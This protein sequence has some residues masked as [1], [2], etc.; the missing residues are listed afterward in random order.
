MTEVGSVKFR[1]ESDGQELAPFAGFEALN[2]A[3]D[4]LRRLGLLGLD[5]NGIGFGNVSLREGSTNFFYIT[6][7]G[8]GGLV[9]LGLTNYARVTAWD[10]ER[11]WL[12]CEGRAIASAESLTHAAIYAVAVEVCVILH[13]HDHTRWHNLLEQGAATAPDVP[14]G[15]PAMAR[16]VQRLFHETA[17]GARKIFAMGGHEAGII[18]FGRDFDEAL[19]ALKRGG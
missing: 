10:L 15:T 1:Y 17:V 13:G 18:A 11:N 14:Y 19:E 3:R 8:T 2:E 5:E 6:G 9:S 7:S 4:E 12:R 16:E